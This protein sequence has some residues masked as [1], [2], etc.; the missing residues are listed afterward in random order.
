[1]R[2]S[3]VEKETDVARLADVVGGGDPKG[4]ELRNGRSSSPHLV[5]ITSSLVGKPR[6][7]NLMS[8]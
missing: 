4:A 1:M 5:I 8:L 7:M 6:Q 3:D 2:L